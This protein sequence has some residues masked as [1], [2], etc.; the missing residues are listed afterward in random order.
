MAKTMLRGIRVSNKAE[1]KRRIE[2]YFEELNR[3]PVTFRWRYKLDEL[4]VA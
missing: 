4:S 1:L 2:L 3:D